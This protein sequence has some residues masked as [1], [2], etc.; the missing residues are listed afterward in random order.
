MDVA[1]V[2]RLN[3]YDLFNRNTLMKILAF[4]AF[5]TVIATPAIAQNA[6]QLDA[7]EHGIGQ[8]GIA[9]DGSQIVMELHVPGADIVGFEYAAESEADR[10]AIDVAVATLAMPLNLFVLPASAGCRVVSAS[11][12]LKSEKNHDAH[13]G[14]HGEEHADEDDGH[15]NHA[16]DSHEDHADETGHTEFYAQ[17]LLDCTDPTAVTDMAFAYFDV[18]PNA[19]EVDVQVVSDGGATSFDVTR[20]ASNLDLRGMF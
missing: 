5:S 18:F 1:K 8:L 6:R 13:D 11:A 3:F 16:E 10:A 12:G 20:D 14:D 19:L 2:A 4:L 7:H 15:D 9:F 17:Y